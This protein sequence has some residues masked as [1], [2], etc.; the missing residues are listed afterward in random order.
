MKTIL[1][2]NEGNT[3]KYQY[4]PL[5]TYFTC[6]GVK[7][8]WG[9]TGAAT[10]REWFC[11][12]WWSL[13]TDFPLALLFAVE[14]VTADY[15]RQYLHPIKVHRSSQKGLS[16]STVIKLWGDTRRRAIRRVEQDRALEGHQPNSSSRRNTARPLKNNL[17]GPN[18]Q[19]Q[20][21]Q[22]R[23]HLY[24]LETGL[25]GTANFFVIAHWHGTLE[26]QK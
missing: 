15:L 24:Y 16:P 25:E 19:K 2:K 20:T 1:L 18:C 13:L 3:G 17:H 26:E 23:H 22:D 21:P 9:G 11:R 4:K 10:T 8:Q 6:F 14:L 5:W 12:W 7:H